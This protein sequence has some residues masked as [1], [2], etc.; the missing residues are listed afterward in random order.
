M[1]MFISDGSLVRLMFASPFVNAFAPLMFRYL[2]CLGENETCL[3][4]RKF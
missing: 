4:A 1:K 2:V 3:L